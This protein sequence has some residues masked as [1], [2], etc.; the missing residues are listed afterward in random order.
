[1]D[2]VLP[3]QMDYSNSQ[4]KK[5]TSKNFLE[6]L[7][8]AQQGSG[9]DQPFSPQERLAQAQKERFFR[10]FPSEF[11]TTR[12]VEKLVFD[13]TQQEVKLQ[14]SALQVELKKLAVSTQKLTREVA[15]AVVEPPVNPG[16]YHVN[17]LEKLRGWLI[18]LKKRIDASATWLSEFNQR[19]KKKNYYWNQ[20]QKSGTKFMLS[21]ERYMTNQAG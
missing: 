6:L 12:S 10:P 19:S 15:V 8:T 5:V 17:F 7:R 20:A 9:G 14:I 16:T 1:M 13:Q 4:K 2:I 11:G 3:G 21:Q 18:L